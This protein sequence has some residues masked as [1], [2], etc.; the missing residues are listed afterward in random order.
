MQYMRHT[1]KQE[2]I[3]QPLYLFNASALPHKA[4]KVGKEGSKN[5]IWERDDRRSQ[6]HCV[7]VSVR[8]C[9]CVCVCV[10]MCATACCEVF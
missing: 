9:V 7:C 1:S 5:G 8:V 2:R 3:K 10:C 4:K 6:K